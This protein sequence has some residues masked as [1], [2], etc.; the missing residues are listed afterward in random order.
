MKSRP[1]ASHF[2]AP[3]LNAT[4]QKKLMTP[5]TRFFVWYACSLILA[6]WWD[7]SGRAT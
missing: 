5:R 7:R 1:L 3:A 4:R 2:D 6:S